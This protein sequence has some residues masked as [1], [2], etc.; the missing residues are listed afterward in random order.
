LS[1]KHKQNEQLTDFYA[2][3]KK[4]FLE[5]RLEIALAAKCKLCK[6]GGL[7]YDLDND[8]NLVCGD[9]DKPEEYKP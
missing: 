3:E 8:G 1:R 7:L 9:C 2:D 5:K 4:K 6:C